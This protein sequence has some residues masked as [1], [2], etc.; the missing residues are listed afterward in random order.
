MESR[1]PSKCIPGFA[2]SFLV[3]SI[4]S[5][6]LLIEKEANEGLKKW[7][8]GLLGHH[9]VTHGA[10]VI[11]LFFILGWLFSRMNYDEQ[12]YGTRTAVII[13]IG[14]VIGSGII[15]FSPWF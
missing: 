4:I 3:V 15:V 12:W 9:W 2:L 14:A 11:A 6:A 7:M 13:V 10:F 8:A 5:A 1:P